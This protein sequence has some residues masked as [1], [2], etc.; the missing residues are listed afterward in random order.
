MI[1]ALILLLTAQA[2]AGLSGTVLDAAGAP[3]GGA[4][5][6]VS[7]GAAAATLTSSA[8]G[9]WSVS[10]ERLAAL[11]AAAGVRVR[12]SADGFTPR[13]YDVSL[14]AAALR[15][16]LDPSGITERVTVSA[17]AAQ[18]LSIEASATTLDAAALASAPALMLDDQ[19][20]A[21]P[22][23][24][25]FRRTSSRVANPT[26]QGA[27]LR[28][29]SASGSSRTLVLADGVPLNDPFG[30]W[31]YWSRIPMA[32]IARVDVI[33]GGSSDVHG[34]EALGGVIRIETR[35]SPG[36]DLRV[37]AGGDQTARVSAY[38]GARMNGWTAG[39]AAEKFTTDGYITIAPESRGPVDVKANASSA[40]AHVWGTGVAGPVTLDLR[41]Q[42][43]D[44][45]RGNGTPLQINA[46][47]TRQVSGGARG[48][49]L[50]G[51]W[52]A[53]ADVGGVNYRQTFTAV[54][55]VART[56]ERLT[57]AQWVGTTAGGASVE[58]VKAAGRIT[59]LFGAAARRVRSNLDEQRFAVTGVPAPVVRTPARQQNVGVTIQWAFRASPRLSIE[60]GARGELWS[61]SRLDDASADRRIGFFEP[62]VTAAVRISD[63]TTFRASWL[64]G[65]RTPTINEL[66]RSFRVGNV[67]TLASASLDPE[68]SAGPEVAL[69][70]TRG[71]FSGRV[72]G[73]ATWLNGA[74]YNKTLS[75]TPAL[76][77][78]QRTNGDVRAAGV[79]VEGEGR[80]APWLVLTA[81]IAG[82]DS[83]FTSGDLDG[84][85]VPQVPRVQGSLGVRLT[86]R[87][88]VSGAIDWRAVGAQFD[89]DL[90]QF[91]LR[92]GSLLD[93]RGGW[94]ATRRLEV[95]LAMENA[96]NED[97]DT[98]R[99]PI[100]TVG[101][102]RVARAGVTARW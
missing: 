26:T 68:E 37:E 100:R 77:T 53:R 99:T 69:V 70:T 51:A 31:V 33:R 59:W 57:N 48:I 94:R 49:A 78:R 67:N 95:F 9:T 71:R 64:S 41:G 56:A 101:Q 19:L 15:T 75:S 62:R 84:L 81:S 21:T 11:G 90:N 83:R 98:G 1:A 93:L 55:D 10:A 86:G 36:A 73:F 24:S 6:E 30:G 40:S 7:K 66:Y 61:S 44:E 46:T 42:Y 50:G 102:P 8:D 13:T 74:L 3:I 23:F 65:F 85:R 89:D 14:P 45:D 54:V 12:V 18:R 96:L 16:V 97:L 88:G 2:G 38:G 4:V 91:V 17:P 87:R 47:V 72:I 32:A 34:D 5:V 76:I 63:A 58:W 60:A 25:L 43:F 92:R 35:A 80:L 20:R 22:G 52:A 28:G 29:L 82:I 27:T 79:E 39:A